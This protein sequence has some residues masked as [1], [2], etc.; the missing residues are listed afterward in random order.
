MV[1]S[2]GRCYHTVWALMAIFVVVGAVGAAAAEQGTMY[3]ALRLTRQGVLD[4]EVWRLVSYPFLTSGPLSLLFTVLIVYY[5]GMPLELMWGTARFLALF[6]VSVLGGA[7]AGVLLNVPLGGESRS[8]ATRPSS[9]SCSST[10]SSF[11][12]ASFTFS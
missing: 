1:K 12:R 6:L 5:I 8:S 10:D 3:D 7:A 4:G 2:W 9:R 11:P